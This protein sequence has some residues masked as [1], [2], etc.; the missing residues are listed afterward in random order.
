M[1]L[2]VSTE[3]DQWVSWGAYHGLI[4][5]LALQVHE[6][7]WA[8]DQILCLARGGLRVGDVLSRIFDKPLAILTTSS[9]RAAAGTEQGRLDIAQYVTMTSGQLEGRVLLLDDMVDTGVTLVEVLASLQ[10][11]FTAITE[12]RTGVLW[13]KAHSCVTPDFYVQKLDSNPWIHQP[14]EE[15]DLLD[16]ATLRVRVKQ[17]ASS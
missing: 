5:Q 3:R 11:R 1:T 15:Y 2:P 6:S 12:I 14:F 7:G 8:F 13:Y 10:E 17:R 4:E 9:Y 16:P